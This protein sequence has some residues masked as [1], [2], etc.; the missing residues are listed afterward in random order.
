MAAMTSPC[1]DWIEPHPH[2]I[3]VRPADAWIDPMR[4]V[5]RALITHGHGDHARGGH[6]AVWATPET[7]AIANL[8]YGRYDQENA[9]PY[10]GEVVLGEVRV[11]WHPAGHVLG[12][13]QI[14]LEHDGQTVVVTPKDPQAFFSRLAY[15]R[16]RCG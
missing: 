15:W 7:L 9:V 3:Y 8:R 4:A 2:G 12:S 14:R 10:G 1:V 6:A 11:S 13:A 5:P 16:E